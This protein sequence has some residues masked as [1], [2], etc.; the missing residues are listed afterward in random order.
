[1]LVHDRYQSISADF[2]RVAG[3]SRIEGNVQCMED[4]RA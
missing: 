3:I 2:R 1:M 4:I